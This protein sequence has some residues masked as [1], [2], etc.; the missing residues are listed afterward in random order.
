MVWQRLDPGSE[1][2]DLGCG[3][4]RDSMFMAKQG[5]KVAAV[6]ENNQSDMIKARRSS[7]QLSI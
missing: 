3:Q 7:F 5:F 4:G 2:L 6:D 1:F